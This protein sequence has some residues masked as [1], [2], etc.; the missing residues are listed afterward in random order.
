MS[1]DKNIDGELGKVAY[2]AFCRQWQ[3]KHPHSGV[4]RK[5]W[6][7]L[8][9]R[10]RACWIEAAYETIQRSIELAAAGAYAQARERKA[11]RRIMDGAE[12]AATSPAAE[13]STKTGERAPPAPRRRA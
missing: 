11:L 9:D 6:A 12:D 7:A 10:V 3:L 4:P 1:R 8:D 2:N 5:G 13:A